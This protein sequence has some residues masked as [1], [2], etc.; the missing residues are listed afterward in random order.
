[1][2]NNLLKFEN[3]VKFYTKNLKGKVEDKT[4]FIN[5]D[6]KDKDAF[7]SLA[8]LTRAAHNLKADV[9]II[10]HDGKSFAVEILHE[11]WETFDEL[12]KNNHNN[13][14]AALKEFINFVNKKT[15][16]KEFYELF[17]KPEVIL[18]S[19]KR[20]FDGTFILPYFSDWRVIHRWK[21]LL[22]TCD[23]IW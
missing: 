6:L 21:E 11:L 12:K 13:K 15:K 23:K 10:M 5:L 3:A 9:H 1:M 8:P 16:S 14:I 17:E 4:L 22:Q 18:N 7:F 19:N 20:E 2:R